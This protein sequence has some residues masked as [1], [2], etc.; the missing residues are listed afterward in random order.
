[1]QSQR[2][3]SWPSENEC[4]QLN[5]IKRSNDVFVDSLDLVDITNKFLNKDFTIDNLYI[6]NKIINNSD[7]S[8]GHYF[9]LDRI[10]N[11]I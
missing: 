4:N 11:N 1:M 3:I 7:N 2:N 6:K 10:V 9:F 8:L 5:Q